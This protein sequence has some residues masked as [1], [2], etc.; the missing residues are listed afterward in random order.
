MSDSLV[1][2]FQESFYQSF[3]RSL[4]ESDADS[5]DVSCTDSFQNQVCEPIADRLL[6]SVGKSLVD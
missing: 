6:D 2:L 4:P 3:H 1:E 5:L